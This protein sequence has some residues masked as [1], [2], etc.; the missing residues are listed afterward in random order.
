MYVRVRGKVKHYTRGYLFPKIFLNEGLSLKSW[1]K[2][3]DE[4]VFHIYEKTD[5][6]LHNVLKPENCRKLQY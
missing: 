3:G 2:W 5:L 6:K 1:K 4:S